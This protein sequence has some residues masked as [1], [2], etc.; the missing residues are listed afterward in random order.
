MD[1]TL[2]DSHLDTVSILLAAD[3]HV[4]GHPVA[5]GGRDLKRKEREISENARI[6][7]ENVSDKM[8]WAGWR[9]ACPAATDATLLS[10]PAFQRGKHL[11]Y[12]SSSYP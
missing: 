2:A 12:M 5:V 1:N 11:K 9:P 7:T 6:R 4:V 3:H 8:A 10:S